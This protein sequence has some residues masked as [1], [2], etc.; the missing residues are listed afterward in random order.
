MKKLLFTILL[1]ASAVFGHDL[2]VL[3]QNLDGKFKADMIYGHNFPS[4]EKIATDRLVLFE[5]VKIYSQN[6]AVEV[7][8]QSGENYHYESDKPLNKGTYIIHSY[9]KPTPWIEKEDGK[10]DMNK[11]RKDTNEKVKYCGISTM[12]GKQILVIDG[13]SGEF[14]SKAVTNG[15]EITPLV[16]AGDIKE[17]KLVKFKLTFN[18]RPV[19]N[20]TIYASYGDYASNPDMAFAG[21][22]KSDLEGN[23]EF[24]PL[25]RGLWYLKTTVNTKSG[26]EDCEILNN[27]ASLSFEVF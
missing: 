1:S 10:W 16:K 19:K 25:K 7:M 2:W 26:N 22:A 3:G 27:K 15:L 21:F 18:G 12:S 6:G 20:A 13:D 5:P 9:Y 23:F 24:R 17:D 14:A 4:P 8:K 11:T